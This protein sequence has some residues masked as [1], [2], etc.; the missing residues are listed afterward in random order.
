MKRLVI[1]LLVLVSVL[2]FATSERFLTIPTSLK[3]YSA[4]KKAQKEDASVKIVSEESAII[5]AIDKAL[6]SVV[7]IGIKKTTRSSDV[8]EINPFDPLSPLRR[9]P[10]EEREIERNIGSGFAIAS[11]YYTYE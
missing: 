7:T 2:Y 6:P 3:K 11:I 1:L 8:F 10:G 4:A 9:T 5:D